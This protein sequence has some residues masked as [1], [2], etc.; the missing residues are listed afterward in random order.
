MHLWRD[1][2]VNRI[3]PTLLELQRA[4]RQDMLGLLNANA[5]ASEHVVADGLDP[6]ARLAIYRNTA[7]AS[8]VAALRLSYPAVQSLVGAEFF[9]GAA[10]LYIEQN[11]PLSAH[12]DS[13]GA[14]FPD[15][16]ARMPEAALLAFLPDAARLEWAVNEVLRAPDA[17]PLD[18]TRVAQLEHDALDSVRFVPS[19]AV[20]LLQSAFPVDVIWQAVLDR[21]DS[22]LA[23]IN[24]VTDPV[25]LM[26]RRSASG[27]GVERVAQ[28]QW[29]FAAT[30]LAGYPLDAAFVEAPEDEA[31]GWLAW[32]LASGCFTD[33]ELLKRALEASTGV[34]VL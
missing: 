32:L 17:K 33:I 25:W 16:L 1:S 20:K 8:L 5:Y 34:L 26:I 13:Y 9:E 28:W 31:H 27:I 23:Q 2:K 14:M 12:L 7:T 19:P 29:Q 6:R 22:A 15:F 4:V 30:L 3:S 10:R 21:D 18:L 24:L 11:P